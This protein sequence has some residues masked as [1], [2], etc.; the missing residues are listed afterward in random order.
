[1]RT[2]SLLRGLPVY[3]K[4]TGEKL[5]EVFDLCLSE[6]GKVD[7]LL[8]KKGTLFKRTT[9]VRIEDVSSFGCDGVMLEEET[10][11]QPVRD[12]AYH[13]FEGREKLI[14][15]PLLSSE[16]EHLG[17]LNDVYFH[18]ELGIIVGYECT[19]GF[20]ADI[21]EGKRIIKSNEPPTI[22]KDAIIVSINQKY[23]KGSFS[24][25]QLS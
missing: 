21:T 9:F 11:A 6:S 20:F 24:N 8:L 2:F 7:G 5:G 14:G 15:K 22:G 13:I 12:P 16:G 3:V 25:V 17:L 18:E 19:D 4:K 10:V 1:M 23:G